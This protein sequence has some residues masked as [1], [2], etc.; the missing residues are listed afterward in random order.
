V[1]GEGGFTVLKSFYHE[2]L[3]NID[4]VEDRRVKDRRRDVAPG[5][6]LGLVWNTTRV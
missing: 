3:R 1:G 5:S 6:L 4:L 2:I